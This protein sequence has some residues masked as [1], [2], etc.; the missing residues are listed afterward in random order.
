MKTD[1]LV[2]A[3]RSFAVDTS[4]TGTGGGSGGG[5]CQAGPVVPG[6]GL[7][8]LPLLMLRRK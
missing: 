6:L 1:A 3:K 2:Q 7:L 4:G 5:G 8:L